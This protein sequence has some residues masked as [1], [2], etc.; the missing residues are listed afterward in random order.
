MRSVRPEIGGHGFRPKTQPIP[1]HG[2]FMIRKPFRLFSACLVLG[3]AAC[4]SSTGVSSSITQADA[5]DL[6]LQIGCSLDHGPFRLRTWIIVLDPAGGS[7]SAAASAPVSINHQFTVTKACP[8][9]G[10]VSLAG[11]LTGSGDATTRQLHP[12]C[13]RNEDRYRLRVPDEERDADTE[14]QPEHHVRRSPEHR[15]C[16][17]VG[18]PDAD[19]QGQL[20]LGARWRL[21]RVRRGHHVVV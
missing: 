18:T 5:N 6:A 8:K 13:H 15:Q 7:G 20:Q 14:R 11:T 12:R 16:G 2:V 1:R 9:G 10:Q 3:I 19:P 21:G 17:A 4:D